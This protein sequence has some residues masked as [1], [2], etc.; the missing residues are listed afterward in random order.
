MAVSWF[1][2]VLFSQQ[3]LE[4]SK[5]FNPKTSCLQQ[6]LRGLSLDIKIY[7][8]RWVILDD[9]KRSWM[10]YAEGWENLILN[11]RACNMGFIIY[12]IIYYKT[13]RNEKNVTSIQ[14]SNFYISISV[15]VNQISVFN[16]FYNLIGIRSCST[17]AW[18]ELKQL[19]CNLTLCYCAFY[20]VILHAFTGNLNVN[21]AWIIS[22]AN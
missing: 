19:P 1:V 3:I 16:L 10:L 17:R 21:K 14:I 9:M 11:K 22:L 13:S 20:I 7:S 8:P 12:F 6:I 2:C 4:R 5:K 15:Y 18:T